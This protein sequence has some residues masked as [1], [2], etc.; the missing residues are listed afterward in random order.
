METGRTKDW[1]HV[2]YFPI[3]EPQ[4]DEEADAGARLSRVHEPRFPPDS[5]SGARGRTTQVTGA[6]GCGRVHL[7]VLQ[8]KT[9][10]ALAL[11]I[12]LTFAIKCLARST[13]CLIRTARSLARNRAGCA[14]WIVER[15]SAGR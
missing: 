12:S 3:D 8:F 15:K 14:H 10:D 5:P 4:Y 6:R 1:K 11:C 7:P 13:A 9:P 2:R